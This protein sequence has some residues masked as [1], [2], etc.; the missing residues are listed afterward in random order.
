MYKNVII[1]GIW[2]IILYQK[3]VSPCE[4]LNALCS[5]LNALRSML[6][7]LY[8]SIYALRLHSNQVV[9]FYFQALQSN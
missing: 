8:S 5:F 9:N 6:Y 7:A 3:I 1:T 2:G 4:S